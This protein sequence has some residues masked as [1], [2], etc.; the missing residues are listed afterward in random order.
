MVTTKAQWQASLD[1]VIDVVLAET[2]DVLKN[3]LAT[4]GVAS[5]LDLL[6]VSPED[7]ETL[8]YTDSS[9]GV[10]LPLPKFKQGLLNCFRFYCDWRVHEGQQIQ[11]GEWLHITRDDF[12]LYRG[13]RD[14]T[15]RVQNLATVTAKVL[16]SNNP[17][18]DF[19]KG[20]KR[21]PTLFPYLKDTKS[22][23]SWQRAMQAQART[24]LVADVLDPNGKPPLGSADEALFE[25]KQ[26]YLYA[27]FE[28]T[29]L[30]HQGKALVRKYEKS[31]DAN[32]LYQEL[33]KYHTQSTSATL[34]SSATFAYVTNVKIGDGQ[35][36]GSSETFIIHWQEN[37]RKYESMVPPSEHL[38]DTHKRTLLENAVHPMEE[39]RIIKT[40]AAQLAVHSGKILTYDQYCDLLISAAQASDRLY[41][42]RPP[43][44]TSRNRRVMTHDSFIQDEGQDEDVFDDSPYHGSYYEANAME[45]HGSM[46]SP[47]PRFRLLYDQWQRLS[48]S[49]Q[50]TWELLPDD[51]K[52]IILEARPTRRGPPPT[53]HSVSPSDQRPN[54]SYAPST[55][56]SPPVTAHASE[57]HITADTSTH[58]A[59]PDYHI[60]PDLQVHL[61]KQ[62]S[63]SASTHPAEPARMLSTPPRAATAPVELVIDGQRYRSVN[64]TTVTYGVSSAT[65]NLRDGALVDRG[66]NGGIAGEDVRVLATTNKTVNVRGIDNHEVCDIPIVTCAGVMHTQRGDVIAIMH[67][68]A[69]TG[70]G[71]TIHSSAQLECFKNDVNDRSNKVDGGLQRI[72]TL[73][74]YIIP[75]HI[76]HGLPYVTLRPH[77]DDEWSNL[78]HIHLTSEQD[79]DPTIIDGEPDEDWFDTVSETITDVSPSFDS[80]GDYRHRHVITTAV[81]HANEHTHIFDT[82]ELMIYE[83]SV[84]PTQPDYSK[85]IRHLAWMPLDVIK[86]TFLCTTQLASIPMSNILRKTFQSPNPAMNILRRREPIATD[87]VYSDTPSIDGGEKIAQIYV[88]VESEVVDIYAIKSEKQFV[89]TLEDNIRQR[90][91]PACLISDSAAVET[92]TRVKDILRSLVIKEWQSEPYHQ[93]QNKAERKY[94]DVKRTAKTIMDRTGA[95][96]NT[97]FLALAYVAFILNRTATPSL[98][99]RTPLEA[100]DGI[101]PDISIMLRFYFYEPVFFRIHEPSFPSQTREA[102]GH[103]VGFSE[104]VGHAMTY[105]ILSQDSGKIVHRSE[106]RT[107]GNKDAPNLIASE[108]TPDPSHNDPFSPESDVIKWGATKTTPQSESNSKMP[109][110]TPVDIIGRTFPLMVPGTEGVQQAAVVR[111]VEKH[112]AGLDED[113]ER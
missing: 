54:R 73:E 112:R 52:A 88:G 32:A 25:E 27:V 51:Q 16:P 83:H 21:D 101:T 74:G 84:T 26:K 2:D 103:F 95:P 36:K 104:T 56:S 113:P 58:T 47:R 49:A 44:S 46:M 55:R 59:T 23:D 70:R 99:H 33:V 108:P 82:R 38:S 61:S 19:R 53:R 69:Y 10:K 92:S 90:G 63:P 97:W 105:K 100:L 60:P 30:H 8:T 85:H 29:L 34:E 80:F 22:W 14:C 17:L 64:A 111:A 96:A 68:Y 50:Q 42:D 78:P 110:F 24:Q 94:Q 102:R 57:T 109:I 40:Q 15:L 107:A 79:W 98:K 37:L 89:N 4:Y 65:R 6:T 86:R 77:T 76:R 72:T 18:A 11:D 106:V 62:K 31:Y 48:E 43:S 1:H 28:R 66:A 45:R 7:L 91:A 5:P 81:I 93:H 13:S 75:I 3:A 41:N 20:S 12:N 87:T 9:S 71:R 35:F 67:N 39:L